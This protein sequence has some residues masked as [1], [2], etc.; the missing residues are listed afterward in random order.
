MTEG[1]EEAGK[2]ALPVLLALLFSGLT[3]KSPAAAEVT[4]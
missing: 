1:Q 3:P 2:E 4:K